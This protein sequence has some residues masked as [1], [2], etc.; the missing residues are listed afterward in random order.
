[1]IIK[2]KR[3]DDLTQFYVAE[4]VG[5]KA[6]SLS[7]RFDGGTQPPQLE[8]IR[9]TGAA[10]IYPSVQFFTA[11][12]NFHQNYARFTILRIL[13]F[14]MAAIYHLTMHHKP[15]NPGKSV[16]RITNNCT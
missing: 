16:T 5:R 4:N 8:T 10:I 3:F 15:L 9:M 7:E 1:M 6:S 11:S 13:S 14:R 2:Y 12:F